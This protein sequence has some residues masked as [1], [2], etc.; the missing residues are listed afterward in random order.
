MKSW[1]RFE[2]LRE[3]LAKFWSI[4]WFCTNLGIRMIVF[5]D[6]EK[7]E[8][9]EIFWKFWRIFQKKVA[10]HKRENCEYL[11][12]LLR[13]SQK[14]QN[15]RL[16]HF[17]MVYFE[18][19]SDLTPPPPQIKLMPKILL[20]SSMP[21]LMTFFTRLSNLSP[22]C[23]LVFPD[24]GVKRIS[25]KQ[26]MLQHAL[27]KISWRNDCVKIVLSLHFLR[28]RRRILGRR[29]ILANPPPPGGLT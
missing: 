5:F 9:K 4:L 20:L 8:K 14:F 7:D 23:P 28:L 3:T 13:I 26:L 27:N 29:T 10:R 11:G 22:F 6:L 25:M 17:S 24:F 12:I 1:R 2:V 18:K 16:N 21:I 19:W 15:S